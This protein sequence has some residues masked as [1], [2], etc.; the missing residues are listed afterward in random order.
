M[1]QSA[2]KQLQPLSS[3]IDSS[4]DGV[5]G[6]VPLPSI[7][8]SLSVNKK[9]DRKQGEIFTSAIYKVMGIIA[10]DQKISTAAMAVLDSLIYDIF[11]RIS[12][13][14]SKMAALRKQSV[15]S[16]R[17]IRASMRLIFPGGLAQHAT[18]G[19]DIALMHYRCSNGR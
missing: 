3:A 1:A 13:E 17:E 15:I 14:A 5:A 11:C 4:E 19:G 7:P 8:G 9:A 18:T 6:G 10:N 12:T 2:T 16:S